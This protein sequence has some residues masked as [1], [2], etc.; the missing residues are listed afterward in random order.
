MV[1]HAL[2]LA[3]PCP[4]M[5]DTAICSML[6]VAYLYGAEFF[7]GAPVRIVFILAPTFRF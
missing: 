2:A 6:T 7:F 1:G 5:T 4:I 3:G